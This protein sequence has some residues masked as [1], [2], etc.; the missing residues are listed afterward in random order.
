VCK[1]T[2]IRKQSDFKRLYADGRRFNS[3]L[4]ALVIVQRPSLTQVRAAFVVSHKIARGVARNKLRRR[5][6][7]AFRL[8]LPRIAGSADIAIITR[9]AA[10]TS[11]Y[12]ELRDALEKLLTE[13][14][15]LTP[16]GP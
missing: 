3:R 11:S 13:A 1:V 8:L 15:L 7:E 16:E 12:W 14:E 5:L 4:I 10:A 9:P 6:R 2:T